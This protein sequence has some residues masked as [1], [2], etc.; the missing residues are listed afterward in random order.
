MIDEAHRTQ[1]GTFGMV[2]NTVLPNAAK[3]AFTGTPLLKSQLT[4]GE[5]GDYIDKYT[6]EQSV[7]DGATLQILYEGREVKTRVEG[8]SLDNLFEEYFSDKTEEEKNEIKRK[9]GIEKAVL[10]APKRIRWV[11]LDIIKH[12]REKIQPNGFKAMIVTSSR[13]AAVLYKNMLDELNS[14]NSNVVISGDHNDPEELR[15][16]TDSSEH[17]KIIKDFVEKDLSDSKCHFIIVKDMLLTG[18]DAPI[19]QV[20]YL[21]RK[22]MDHGLLQAIARVNRPKEGKQRGFVVDYYGLASY[23]ASALDQFTQS[24]VEGVLK[25]LK[26]EIPK[27]DRAYNKVLEFFAKS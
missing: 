14:P 18:F 4:T 5:F 2:L 27:L 17:K 3:I 8:E 23:L 15:K 11:C 21:D 9:Y 7:E 1:Y 22:I 16:Y 19:C 26:D 10:E 13:H 20:M 6:I 25:E 12:Y 24:D